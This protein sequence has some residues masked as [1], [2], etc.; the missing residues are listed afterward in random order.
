MNYTKADSE[1]LLRVD[2][3]LFCPFLENFI[4]PTSLVLMLQVIQHIAY[5]FSDTHNSHVTSSS[6]LHIASPTYVCC[7]GSV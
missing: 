3:T 7:A 1:Q 4:A 2:T 6:Q 5:L